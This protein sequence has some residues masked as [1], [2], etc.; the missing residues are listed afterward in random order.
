MTAA[1]V[2]EQ[3]ERVDEIRKTLQRYRATWG[4]RSESIDAAYHVAI[5]EIERLAAKLRGVRPKLTVDPKK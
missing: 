2:H 1:Q 3:L 5:V 4:G